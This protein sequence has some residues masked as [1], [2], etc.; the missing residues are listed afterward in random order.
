MSVILVVIMVA[1]CNRADHIYFHAVSSFF[2]YFLAKSQPSE[3][4][5]LPYFHTW[6]G[7][8]ANLECR[9]EMC[10]M[11]LAENT[12]RKNDAK[13]RHLVSG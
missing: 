4:G 2:F 8:S 5:S 7:L 3:I 12:G 9:S 6:C 10:C 1:L 13:N 11:W